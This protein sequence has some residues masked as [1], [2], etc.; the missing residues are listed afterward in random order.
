MNNA[1]T[2]I[3]GG[4]QLVDTQR[5]IT[6]FSYNYICLRNNIQPLTEKRPRNFRYKIALR[7]TIYILVDEFNIPLNIVCDTLNISF[8]S[9]C[10]LYADAVQL[11]N[12]SKAYPRL[13]Y[14]YTSGILRHI[15]PILGLSYTQSSF[16]Q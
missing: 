16:N 14:D 6:R 5:Y 8:Q 10:T 15:P 11:A 12:R 7:A 2:Y 1:K 3:G 13:I 4:G 9:A